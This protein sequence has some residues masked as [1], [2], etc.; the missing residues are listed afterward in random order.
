M[1]SFNNSDLIE[2]EERGYNAKYFENE[3]NCNDCDY[4][5]N[6]PRK[7]KAHRNSIHNIIKYKSAVKTLQHR[8][9]SLNTRT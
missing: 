1:E 9:V 5:T 2:E 3:F 6:Q 8:G 7:L 4:T